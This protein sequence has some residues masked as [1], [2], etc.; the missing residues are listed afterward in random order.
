[1]TTLL[2]ALGYDQERIMQ[3]FYGTVPFRLSKDGNGWITKFFPERHKNTKPE[4]DIVDAATGEIIAPQGK[5][6]TPRTVDNWLKEGTVKEVIVPFDRI[7][8]RYIA[9]DTIDEQTARSGWRPATS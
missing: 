3:E 5:K 6:I 8:G 9:N 4:E 7:K 1:M 2:Y